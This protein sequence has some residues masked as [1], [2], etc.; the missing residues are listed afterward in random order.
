[1]GQI[2]SSGQQ[3]VVATR[4]L[5]LPRTRW[6]IVG[7]MV[8]VA[9]WAVVGGDPSSQ[10]VVAAKSPAS[11][12]ASSPVVRA[13]LMVR[14]KVQDASSAVRDQLDDVRESAHRHSLGSAVEDRL[15][16]DGSIDVAR[17]EV[18]CQ[19]EGAVALKGSVADADAKEYAVEV[20]RATPGVTRVEDH[21]AIPPAPRIF[22]TPVAEEASAPRSSRR[23][24]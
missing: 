17:I 21:L 24:R 15:V 20:A 11:E 23:L 7:F 2:S 14:N 18:D 12:T 8:G 6:A 3:V 22:D 5:P 1:M 9:T 10:K 19:G 16:Q 13:A 4:G